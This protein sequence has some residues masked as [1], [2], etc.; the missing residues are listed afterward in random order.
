MCLAPMTT[1]SRDESTGRG[2]RTHM[3]RRFPN[4]FGMAKADTASSG[5]P[6][7]DPGVV[8]KT[9]ITALSQ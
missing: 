2:M 4:P 3:Y 8:V 6:T 1:P 5:P 7:T 9:L